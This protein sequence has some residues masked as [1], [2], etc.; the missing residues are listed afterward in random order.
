MASILRIIA[1]FLIWNK[2]KTDN[3]AIPKSGDELIFI[4]RPAVLS[5]LPLV[6][7]AKFLNA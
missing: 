4:G 1:N 6:E 2:L 3:A 7:P 5:V